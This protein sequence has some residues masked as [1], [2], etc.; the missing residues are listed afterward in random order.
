[1]LNARAR[2]AALDGDHVTGSAHHRLTRRLSIALALAVAA[3]GAPGERTLRQTAHRWFAAIQERDYQEL[4]KVDASAPA[5]R[6]GPAFEAWKRAVRAAL[7]RHEVDRDRGV[8]EPDEQGYRLVRAMQLGRGAFW[9][10][11]DLRQGESGPILR[12][13]VN[14]GYGEISYWRLEAGSTIY[15]LG[16][17]L[18]TVHA[19]ELGRGKAHEIDVLEHL[20]VRVYFTEDEAALPGDAAYKV[21]RVEWVPDSA[22]HESVRWVF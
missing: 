20:D 7:E 5:D 16:W 6:E 15:L 2:R 17:P 19:I 4:A 3:C 13:R 1:M 21:R 10:V 11:V 22:V 8:L 18:G 12:I 14:F 9:E